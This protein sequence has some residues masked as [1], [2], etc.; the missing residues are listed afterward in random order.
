MQF[1]KATEC[2]LL[3]LTHLARKKNFSA[4]VSEIARAE[5]LSLYF[6]RNVFQKLRAAKLVESSRGRGFTLAKKPA[7][8]SLKNVLDAVEQKTTIHACLR[9]KSVNCARA[10]KCKIVRQLARVQ[11]N[12]DA[13][14][15]KIRITDLI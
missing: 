4:S 7:R 3:G 8:I 14:L 6:L 11:K 5:N 2:A 1:S 10:A 13:E 15:A 12:L 9:K